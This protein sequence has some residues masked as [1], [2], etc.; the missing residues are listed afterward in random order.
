MIDVNFKGAM[1]NALFKKALY[2]YD[3]KKGGRK[4]KY[5]NII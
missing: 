4:K 5:Y 2:C 3:G 1:S